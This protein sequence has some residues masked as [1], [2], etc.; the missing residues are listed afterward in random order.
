M[1]VCLICHVIGN[2]LFGISTEFKGLTLV[3]RI[4]NLCFRK[5]LHTDGNLWYFYF[6]T[7]FMNIT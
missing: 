7:E 1:I 6:G 2:S 3:P 4:N 5:H